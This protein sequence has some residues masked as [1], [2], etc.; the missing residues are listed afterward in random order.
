MTILSTF[1]C[2]E[3]IQTATVAKYRKCHLPQSQS[4]FCSDSAVTKDMHRGTWEPWH[5]SW[6]DTHF[7]KKENYSET[8]GRDSLSCSHSVNTLV[9][10]FWLSIRSSFSGSTGIDA[11]YSIKKICRQMWNLV[12][13]RSCDYMAVDDILATTIINKFLTGY[14]FCLASRKGS[15]KNNEVQAWIILQTIHISHYWILR[16]KSS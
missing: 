2:D 4:H 9:E 11:V 14:F 7:L 3:D 8:S 13:H 1:S 5:L 12:Y 15:L 6:E 16:L 10:F